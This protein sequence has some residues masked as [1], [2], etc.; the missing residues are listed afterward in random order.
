MFLLIFTVDMFW[1][2]LSVVASKTSNDIT[3]IWRF[4][5]EP[6]LDFHIVTVF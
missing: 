6:G 3:C 2:A 1:S 5:D 4:R